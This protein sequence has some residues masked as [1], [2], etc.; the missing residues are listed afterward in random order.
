MKNEKIFKKKIEKYLIMP[1]AISLILLVMCGVLYV[2][3]KKAG[4]ILSRSANLD[5]VNPLSLITKMI[6]SF[7]KSP[8]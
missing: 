5:F 1:M 8:P 4:V 2:Y 3:D 6:L 7:T